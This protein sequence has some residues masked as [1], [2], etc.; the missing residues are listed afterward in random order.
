MAPDT[1]LPPPAPVARR[2]RDSEATA[3]PPSWPKTGMRHAIKAAIL[4]SPSRP[5]DQ[6]LYWGIRTLIEATK[7]LGFPVVVTFLVLW[8]GYRFGTSFIDAQ[9][10]ALATQQQLLA[11]NYTATLYAQSRSTDAI[12][13]LAAAQTESNELTRSLMMDVGL[14]PPPKRR[15]SR[16]ER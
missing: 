15:A 11:Q 13:D 6:V 16:S 3:S 2:A 7:S 10:T 1:T 12:K 14:H 5:Q 9:K 4:R 8:G